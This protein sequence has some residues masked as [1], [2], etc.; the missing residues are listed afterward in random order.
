MKDGLLTFDIL[1]AEFT[2]RQGLIFV[3]P[4]CDNQSELP[5]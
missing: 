5:Y 2:Q 4:V 1:P 3:F